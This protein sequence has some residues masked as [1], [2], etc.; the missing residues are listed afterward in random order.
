MFV[1]SG[2]WLSFVTSLVLVCDIL[3]II[4]MTEPL[5]ISIQSVRIDL[6]KEYYHFQRFISCSEGASIY[7]RKC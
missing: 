4:T 6:N 7:I 5:T 1:L 2:G 3:V